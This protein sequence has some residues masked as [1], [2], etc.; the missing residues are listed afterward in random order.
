MKATV[1]TFVSLAA[2][3]LP[4]AA[5]A[6]HALHNSHSHIKPVSVMK[7]TGPA[8]KPNGAGSSGGDVMPATQSGHRAPGD[9]L[10][11]MYHGGG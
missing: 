11:P 10:D 6:H 3:W 5:S 2:L 8:T 7:G 9:S 4:L 1:F